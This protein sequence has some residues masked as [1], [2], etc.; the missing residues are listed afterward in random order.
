MFH[1]AKRRAR[2][3]GVPFTI[4]EADLVIPTHCPALGLPLAHGEGKIDGAS[5]SLDRIRPELGYV[6]GNVVVI[7]ERANRIKTDAASAEILAVGRWLDSL[8]A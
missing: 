8:G 6:K 4:T 2:M 5:P 7:S 1:R 3:A